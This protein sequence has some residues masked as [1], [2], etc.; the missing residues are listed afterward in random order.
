MKSNDLSTFEDTLL[1]ICFVHIL[2]FN[3]SNTE[4]AKIKNKIN[5]C[6]LITLILLG[7]LYFRLIW[8]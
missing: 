8:I 6:L 4:K 5:C 1:K 2:S 3:K 7:V